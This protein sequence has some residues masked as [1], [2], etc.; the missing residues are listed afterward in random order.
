MPRLHFHF[1]THDQEFPDTIGYEI[2]DL[3][4]AHFKAIQLA[5]RVRMFSAANRASDLRRLI[6][7]V[8]DERQHSVLPLYSRRALCEDNVN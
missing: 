4:A 7:K 8:T 2:N 6:V 1:L 3:A 5:D